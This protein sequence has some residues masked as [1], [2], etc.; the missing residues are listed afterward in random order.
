MCGTVEYCRE[1]RLHTRL[2]VVSTIGTIA[3]AT[4]A[5]L[6][7]SNGSLAAGLFLVGVSLAVHIAGAQGRFTRVEPYLTASQV[8]TVQDY[9]ELKDT[10]HGFKDTVENVDED[11][12]L[13]TGEV[14]LVL[15]R[16]D[17]G[18]N[19]RNNRRRF[20]EAFSLGEGFRH[21]G[22]YVDEDMA[23]YRA[24][25]GSNYVLRPCSEY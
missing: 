2:L 3:I 5:K 1:R 15:T 22:V 20:C 16:L 6:Q 11:L 21:L 17:E 8:V 10:V 4:L 18:D 13:L 12:T 9:H 14:A 24:L 23:R 19:I 7:I 25:S